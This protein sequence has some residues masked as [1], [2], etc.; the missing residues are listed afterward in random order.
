MAVGW[1]SGE[2]KIGIRFED[3]H[4][5]LEA[6]LLKRTAVGGSRGLAAINVEAVR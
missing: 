4:L 1:P 5:A 3:L 2:A 6:M